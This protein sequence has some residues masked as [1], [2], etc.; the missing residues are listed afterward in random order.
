MNSCGELRMIS[1]ELLMQMFTVLAEQ[2]DVG[3]R[4]LKDLW[5]GHR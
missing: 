1:H 4:A 5:H 2:D 3:V